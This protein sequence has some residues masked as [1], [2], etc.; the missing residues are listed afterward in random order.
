M[1]RFS[2]WWPFRKVRSSE[3]TPHPWRWVRLFAFAAFLTSLSPAWAQW[4]EPVPMEPQFGT[5]V[6]APWISNDNLRLYLCTID[7]VFVTCRDSVN[8]A[9]GPLNVLP[10]HI[11]ASTTQNS[12]CESPSG[13]TLYFVSDSDQR[14]EGGYGWYDIYYSVRTDTGWGPVF[15]CGANI[16][17]PGREWSVGIS[18]DGETLLISAD[19]VLYLSTKQSNGAWGLRVDLGFSFGFNEHPSLSPDGARLFFYHSGENMGDI[20]E[21]TLLDSV[22]QEPRPLPAPVNG[23]FTTE[24]NPCLSGDGRTLWFR[25]Q[26]EWNGDFQIATC[27]DTSVMGL[28]NPS[29]RDRQAT[30]L[31]AQAVASDPGRLVLRLDGV[32]YATEHEVRVTNLLGQTVLTRVIPFSHSELGDVARLEIPPLA[33]GV[34]VVSVSVGRRNLTSKFIITH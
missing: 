8:G 18:R 26:T 13:D 33:N 16:N 11:N 12:A 22:W 1:R 5:S 28:T 19:G 15:N 24:M 21:S 6:R 25:R 20:F 4:T 27:V 2:S 23:H 3:L 9:W 17:G 34:Y 10:P 7:F 30:R 29:D 32:E 31:S 14:S